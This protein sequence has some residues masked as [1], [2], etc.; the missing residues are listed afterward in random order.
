[1][2]QLPCPALWLSAVK[3]D[4]SA[5]IELRWGTDEEQGNNAKFQAAK[6]RQGSYY[7]LRRRQHG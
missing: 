1:M 5:C 6:R 2:D 3:D 7:L 4:D